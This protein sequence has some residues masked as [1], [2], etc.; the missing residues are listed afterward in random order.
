MNVTIKGMKMKVFAISDLHLSINSNKPMNIFGPVWENY[1]QDIEKSWSE[2]VKEDD[3]VLIPGDISWALKLEDAIPDLEYI[4]RF[5]GKKI[6]LRGNHD[7]WWS[8][9]TALRNVLPSGM[10][11]IQNDAIKFGN[12]IFCGSRG[13][14]MPENDVFKSS[15]DEKIYKREVL[16]LEL[17]LKH[18]QSLYREGDIIIALTHY[19]PFNFKLEDS[20]FTKLFEQYGVKKVVY[21]HLHNY[22]MHNKLTNEK[23]GITY[24]L[25][26]CDL[27]G[28]VLTEIL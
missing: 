5:K 12:V 13:W 27:V 2:L 11:A 17:S 3:I 24:Y 28:N 21:G 4:N 9:L 1:L 16:R 19:P 6:I 10:Y 18:A 20:E 8:S 25:T 15:E 14:T 26:S 22:D 23:N 7:Y